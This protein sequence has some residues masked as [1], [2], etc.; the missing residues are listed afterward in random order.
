MYKSTAR[1]K[2]PLMSTIPPCLQFDEFSIY[3]TTSARVHHQLKRSYT[4]FVSKQELVYSKSKN[5]D[6]KYHD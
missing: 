3:L 1:H 6:N 4:T 2:L 5:D